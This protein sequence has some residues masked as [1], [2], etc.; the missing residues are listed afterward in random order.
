M[1]ARRCGV[2][3]VCEMQRTLASP[4]TVVYNSLSADHADLLDSFQISTEDH[5]HIHQSFYL[6]SVSQ[7]TP[8]Y[9]SPSYASITTAQHHRF[10]THAVHN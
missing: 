8:S 7:I 6:F 2:H 5:T 9:A 10:T 1:L 3:S 4:Q